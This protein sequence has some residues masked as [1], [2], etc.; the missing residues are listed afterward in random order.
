[1]RLVV[2]SGSFNLF[3]L[4]AVLIAAVLLGSCRFSAN[5]STTAVTTT[6]TVIETTIE[7]TPPTEPPLP[8]IFY[9]PLPAG[10]N[11]R[12][13]L[14][15]DGESENFSYTVI[16]EFHAN[17]TFNGIVMAWEGDNFLTD[18][19]FLT[20]LNADDSF[21]DLA[22]QE[23]GP[24]D[25]YLVTFY[26]FN[27]ASLVSR[28]SVQGTICDPYSPTIV[29]DP[30]GQGTIQLDGFGRL[31]ALARGNVLHTWY[32]DQPWHVGV[33]GQ[34]QQIPQQYAA[35]ASF[36][37]LTGDRLPET[38]VSLLMDLPL[39]AVPGDSDP[40]L[41]AE[42]G[43]T[44]SLIWTDDVEWIQMRTQKGE[45]G[46]FQLTD[47]GLSVLVGAQAFYGGEVFDGLFFAD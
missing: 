36:D 41:V 18:W 30:Y 10:I 22:V 27:G 4:P 47:G 3:V 24:S 21:L 38:A 15:A 42:V 39:Y 31:I 35:M 40:T 46:W 33:G 19:F 6:E 26:Y 8:D 45:L 11:H 20:D 32:Y 5:T 13:D 9:Q 29:T 25:D 16:D 7:T 44:G 12:F 34:L 1:M 14:N 17:L 2:K 28:G 43:E 23:L 37:L